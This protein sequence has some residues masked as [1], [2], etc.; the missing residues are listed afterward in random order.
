M[1]TLVAISIL[2]LVIAAPLELA[3]KSIGYTSVSQNQIVAYYLAQ[4]GMEFVNAKIK[5]NKIQERHWLVGLARVVGAP[6]RSPN[7]CYINVFDDSVVQCSAG[8]CPNFKYD[9]FL[10]FPYN[11][12]TGN[13]ASFVRSITIKNQNS[14]GEPVNPLEP[15]DARKIEVTISWSE[16]AGTKSITLEENVFNTQ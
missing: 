15:G 12:N 10:D 6:C 11:Y 3:V 9:E 1:E 2:M 7:Y 14:D 8:I 13:N 5:S 16:K 4:E